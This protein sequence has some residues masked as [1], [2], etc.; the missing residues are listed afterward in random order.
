MDKLKDMHGQVVMVTGS[1]GGIGKA[2]ATGL[3]KLGAQ[4]VIVGRNKA[5][6]EAALD[7]IREQS[8]NPN[9]ELM[10]ADLSSQADV[11]RL[12][13]EFN[14][15]SDRLHVLVNNVGGLY[16]RR[17]EI[18]DGI[19]ATFA[20]NYLNGFLLT[21]LL[22]PTLKAGA[23]AR[24]VNVNSGGHRQAALK[25]DDLQS[26]QGYQPLDAY[27][28]AKLASVMF[29]YELARRLAGTGVTANAADPGGA[30]TE[31]TRAITPD[32]LPP[33]M[34]LM[35]PLTPLFRV[36][37]GTPTVE[38]AAWSSVYLAAS[39]EVEGVTG[40]YFSPRGK[41]VQSS[42]ASYDVEAARRLWEISESLVAPYLQAEPL[43]I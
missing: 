40:Q 42:K 7:D 20:T 43:A 25:F 26:Q 24:I 5:R 30:D 6:G 19:E 39:L 23:P 35:W 37:M 29:T 11:A 12:A 36:L 10:L 3:A 28:R 17:Q 31:S 16:A 13:A 9:I 34:R 15:R 32:M 2:T 41:A 18:T 8:G 4:V 27:G 38:K 33:F 22:L 14:A 21:R 1:T